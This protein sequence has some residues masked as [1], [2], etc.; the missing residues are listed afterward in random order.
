MP[1]DDFRF[2]LAAGDEEAQRFVAYIDE[3]GDEGGNARV[4]EIYERAQS[5]FEPF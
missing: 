5:E 3:A 1:R 4:I 2:W